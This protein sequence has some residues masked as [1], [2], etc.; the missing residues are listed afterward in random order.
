MYPRDDGFLNAINLIKITF[1]NN[2][3][4]LTDLPFCYLNETY[5][6]PLKN[7][8]TEKIVLFTSEE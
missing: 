8:R 2:T 1:D 6:N 4:E 7:N 3:N 5:I